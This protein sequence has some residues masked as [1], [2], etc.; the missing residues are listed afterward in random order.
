MITAQMRDSALRLLLDAV[1]IYSPSEKEGE[2]AQMLSEKMSGEFGF[3]NVRIDEAGNVIG[4]AG[5]GKLHLL[6]CGH[7]DT[8]PGELP[9]LVENETLFGRGAS[10][11]KSP[12]CAMIVATSMLKTDGL[13]V[14]LAAVTR[15]EGDSLGVDRLVERGDDYDFAVFGEPAGAS[16]ITV[17]YRG[18][19]AVHVT[20]RTEGGHASSPWAHT[21]AIDESMR[22]LKKVEEYERTHSVKDNHYRSVSSCLTLINGGTYANVVPDVCQMTLDVRVP[23]GMDCEGVREGLAALTREQGAENAAVRIGLSFDEATEPYESDAGSLLVRSFQR[24]IIKN[25]SERPVLI[26]KTGTGDMNTLAERM[27]IPAVTY[28]PGDSKLEHTSREAVAISDYLRSIEVLRGVFD[29][30]VAL[31]ATSGGPDKNDESG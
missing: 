11:A 15:E 16:K 7:M 8:V 12:L 3:R 13:R 24:S 22:F 28:G 6:L 10:D 18:R 23:I 14:T 5:S 4:E 29:E 9:V 20:V 25:L 26:H 31:A 21:S 2:L 17:G 27:S 30:I 19:M 1:K